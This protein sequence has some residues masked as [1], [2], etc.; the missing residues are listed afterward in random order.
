M[1]SDMMRRKKR[2]KR[3]KRRRRRR[4]KRR[5]K[6]IHCCHPEERRR[7]EGRRGRRKR[8]SMW[9]T[10]SSRKA[11]ACSLLSYLK[12][13]KINYFPF[14]TSKEKEKEKE[15]KKEEGRRVH[16]AGGL[17]EASG[18][19]HLCCSPFPIDPLNNIINNY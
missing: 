6:Q 13:D 11:L 5:R 3:R 16:F 15:K 9:L 12:K 14:I 17:Q 8:Y 10:W 18:P 7:G 2:R 1:N 4:R 19:R